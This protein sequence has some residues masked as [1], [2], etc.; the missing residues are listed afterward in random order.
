MKAKQLQ[1]FITHFNYFDMN[2]LNDKTAIDSTSKTEMELVEKEKQEYYFLGTFL[3]T[4]GL[5]LF[6]YNQTKDE[7]FFVE[8]KRKESAQI[9]IDGSELKITG[10]ADEKCTVDSRMIY[11]EALNM[12]SASRRVRRFNEGE[13]K[14]LFNLKTPN[15]EGINF[16]KTMKQ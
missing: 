7:I 8:T 6:G 13:I 3:R 1:N 9:E 14:S 16:F 12:K 15:P 5:T 11:F 4:P 10:T 2:I